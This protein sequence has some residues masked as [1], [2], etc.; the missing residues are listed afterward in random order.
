MSRRQ[1]PRREADLWNKRV[2][3][4]ATVEYREVSDAEPQMLTTRTS[5]E[6]L[7]GHTSVVWLNGK[8]GCVCTS[9]CR[10]APINATTQ[11]QQSKGEQ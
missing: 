11:D 3:V 6:V 5:A 8:A 9:H 7:S 2:P 4:G 1:N 10:L